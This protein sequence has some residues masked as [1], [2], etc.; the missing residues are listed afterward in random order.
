MEDLRNL[1]KSRNFI[2]KYNKES[3]ERFKL[4][5]YMGRFV[6]ERSLRLQ[7]G[8]FIHSANVH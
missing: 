7:E 5:N 8:T 3:S 1:P 4:G 2:W 6:L